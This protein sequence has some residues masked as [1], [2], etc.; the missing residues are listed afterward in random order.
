M[1]MI[2]FDD[3]GREEEK[4]VGE[5]ASPGLGVCM[6]RRGQSE[7]GIPMSGLFTAS[8]S[9]VLFTVLLWAALCTPLGVCTTSSGAYGARHWASS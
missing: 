8:E 5:A 7:G 6:Q 4:A 2:L 3:G 9:P 1:T